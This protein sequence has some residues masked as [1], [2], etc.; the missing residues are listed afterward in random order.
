MVDKAQNDA[1]NFF[2]NPAG[3]FA[4]GWVATAMSYLIL[5]SSFAC[6]MA[7]HN[8]AA[9][10]LYAMGRERILPAAL[11]R[12]HHHYR[13]PYVASFLQTGI[14]VVVLAL[15]AIF[16]GSNDPN[17]QAYTEVYGL[18]SLMGTMLILAAQAVVSL[19]IVAYFWR[20]HREDFHWWTTLIAPVLAF[21]A[22]A[23]VIWLCLTNI[24]VIGGGLAIANWLAPLDLVILLL[25]FAG[26]LALKHR[27][28]ARYE[29]VGRMIFEGLP[30]GTLVMG[31]HAEEAL[32][33]RRTIGA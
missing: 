12:T 15:F 18:L 6:G 9:R 1:S 28:P 22:Q 31:E 19:A 8:T 21:V 7:F 4:G 30:E 13:S 11:G 27:D 32:A 25:G 16:G 10:Y 20:E 26:A 2:L 29:Q 3:Q 23:L 33:H 24:D 14:S 5:T 17:A